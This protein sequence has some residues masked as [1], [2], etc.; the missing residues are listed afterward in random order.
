MCQCLT[1]VWGMMIS[2]MRVEERNIF[3]DVNVRD[4]DEWTL[5]T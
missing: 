3:I 4:D 2:M 5:H 1:Y